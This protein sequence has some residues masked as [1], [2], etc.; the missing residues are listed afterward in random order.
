MQVLI[1]AVA[2]IGGALALR[3]WLDMRARAPSEGA[4]EF[5][6]REPGRIPL[7]V[8]GDSDSHAYHDA[9]WSDPSGRGGIEFHDVTYQWTEILAVTRP[10]ELDPGRWGTWGLGPKGSLLQSWLGG[11]GRSP[12]KMDFERV[13]AISGAGCD[14]LNPQWL[15][16]AIAADPEHWSAGVVLV[17]I[18]IN[19]LLRDWQIEEY[20]ATGLSPESSRSVQHCVAEIKAAVD[21]I[22][23]K[24]SQV[25][26]ALVG[27][28][29]EHE[30][31]ELTGRWPEDEQLARIGE[32]IDDFDSRVR[33]IAAADARAVFI[34]DREWFAQTWIKSGQGSGREDRTFSLGGSRAVGFSQGD[35]PYHLQL[36]DGH[37]GTV[38]NGLFARHVQRTLNQK[39]GLGLSP[40]LDAEIADLADPEGQFG[41]APAKTS[42]SESGPRIEFSVSRLEL[43][44]QD[45]PA[46]LPDFQARDGSGGDL[47]STAVAFALNSEDSAMARAAPL[48]LFGDGKDLELRPERHRRGKYLVKIQVRDRLGRRAEAELDLRIN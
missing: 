16:A 41:L 22:R 9:V 3:I 42:Q 6:R 20:A 43:P 13:Y 44:W 23:G 24:S 48:W 25:A 15:A 18:G 32:V 4:S 28:F 31:P 29:D 12:R 47:S 39:L 19:S 5:H 36:G 45:L 21:L 27:L 46:G 10:G 17:R 7:A 35:Q 1:G 34:E 2:V 37:G 14:G 30:T 38:V 26:I 40:L 11:S 33:E 8:L